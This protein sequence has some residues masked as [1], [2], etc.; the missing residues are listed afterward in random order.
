MAT[1]L[2]G[3]TILKWRHRK[4]RHGGEVLWL[5]LAGVWHEPGGNVKMYIKMKDLFS[6]KPSPALIY[7]L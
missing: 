6:H 2:L 1:C 3:S 4:N 5:L 7:A